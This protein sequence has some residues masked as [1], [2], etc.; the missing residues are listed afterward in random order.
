MPGT[1][2]SLT[3]LMT[4]SKEPVNVLV[5]SKKD[6]LLKVNMRRKNVMRTS[7]QVREHLERLKPSRLALLE[8]EEPCEQ[9][10][11]KQDADPV[12]GQD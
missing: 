11:P 10:E 8:M 3:K 5:D 12:V 4:D 6:K 2:F 1:D 7:D 9:A